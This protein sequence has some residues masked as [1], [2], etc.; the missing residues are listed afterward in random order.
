MTAMSLNSADG[1]GNPWRRLIWGAAAALLAVPLIAMQFTREVNWTA[2]DF[3]VFAVMLAIA[4]GIYELGTRLS[5][6]TAYR[7][8][9]AIAIANGFL[10]VWANLAVGI[11]EGEANPANLMFAGV[12][13]VAAVG[14]LLAKFRPRGMMLAL[15]A[16]A[17]AQGVV[18]IIAYGLGSA[19]GAIMSLILGLPWLVSAL[20]FR[21]AAKI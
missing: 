15:L 12:L 21:R 14:A 18:A 4:C 7:A 2:S 10:I 20:F 17:M 1:K 19:G 5:G 9:F 13:G 8:G 16:T 3:A 11:I 6:S